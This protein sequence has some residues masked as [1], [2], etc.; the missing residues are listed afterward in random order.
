MKKEGSTSSPKKSVKK[1]D[2]LQKYKE[3]QR[4][5]FDQRV[6]NLESQRKKKEDEVKQKE[7]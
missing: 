1:V 7:A 6:N 2:D 3:E 4:R 5:K